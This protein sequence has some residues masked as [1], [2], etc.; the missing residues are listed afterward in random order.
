[1]MRRLLA[2]YFPEGEFTIEEDTGFLWRLLH[3]TRGRF[4]FYTGQRLRSV[5]RALAEYKGVTTLPDL[6]E[7]SEN[8]EGLLFPVGRVTRLN[9]STLDDMLFGT[10]HSIEMKDG[11]LF[12]EYR[13]VKLGHARREI[14]ATSENQTWE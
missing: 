13:P 10:A 5:V 7:R 1:M 4:W 14:F 12:W 9:A 6:W 8:E 3:K 2:E 11:R